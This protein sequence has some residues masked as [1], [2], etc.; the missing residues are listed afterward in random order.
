V[1]GGRELAGSEPTALPQPKPVSAATEQA[2]SRL[3]AGIRAPDLPEMTPQVLEDDRSPA[4]SGE[5]TA[6]Q[7][8]VTEGLASGKYEE[9]ERLIRNFLNIPR[10]PD[11]EARAHYYLGQALYLRG[12]PREA[13]LE[14]LL[15]ED[16]FYGQTRPWLDACYRKLSAADTA[17]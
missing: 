16:Q 15:A 4:V 12:Q 2:I 1:E 9:A 7:Q 13:V 17:G 3:L 10:K 14:F 6:L 5:R 8:I 11:L